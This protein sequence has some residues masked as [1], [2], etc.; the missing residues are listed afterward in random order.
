MKIGKQ[1][2]ILPGRTRRQVFAEPE[3]AFHAYVSNRLE[4]IGNGQIVVF[5]HVVTNVDTT[6]SAS[7]LNF[8]LFYWYDS[9]Q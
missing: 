1:V 5:D 3:I 4:H 6:L 8:I 7:N 2:K 9:T